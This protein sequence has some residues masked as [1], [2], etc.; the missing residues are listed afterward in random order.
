MWWHVVLLCNGRETA[1]ITDRFRTFDMLV[2]GKL[3][4]IKTT[5]VLPNGYKYGMR[6]C[7]SLLA[8]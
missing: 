5:A 7:Q 6:L 1:G 4:Q 2:E 3:S 8:E